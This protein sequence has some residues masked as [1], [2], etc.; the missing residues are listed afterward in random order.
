[1]QC[2]ILNISQKDDSAVEDKTE[3]VHLKFLKMPTLYLCICV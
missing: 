1:M 3:L 2:L